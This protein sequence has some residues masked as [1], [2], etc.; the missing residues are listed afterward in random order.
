M[1][2]ELTDVGVRELRSPSEV[3][4]VLESPGTVM[5]V[6]NSICGCAAGKARPGIVMA[7]EHE[8]RPMWWPRYSLVPTSRPPSAHARRSCHIHRLR[9]QWRCCGTASL[10]TY[11][12][13]VRSKRGMRGRLLTCSGRHSTSTAK[14]L[15]HRRSS[16]PN[17]QS[18]NPN[19]SLLE[20]GSWSLGVDCCFI[21]PACASPD[22]GRGGDDRPESAASGRAMRG[23]PRH[24]DRFAPPM[25]HEST[26]RG[27]RHWPR[28]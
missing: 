15:Q 1:R 21:P 12:S 27:V 10:S 17:S 9:R 13:V 18:P 16:T 24:H 23:A 5:I 28:P 2:A 20:V 11:S 6:V 26:E 3:E 7:L 14:R 8:R 22:A 25:S 4:D 19:T